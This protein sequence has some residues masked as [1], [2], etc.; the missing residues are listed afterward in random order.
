[1]TRQMSLRGRK[2][3]PGP[4]YGDGELRD[5]KIAERQELQFRG[6]GNS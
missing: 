5:P 2:G 6:F 1:M 3:K 4:S